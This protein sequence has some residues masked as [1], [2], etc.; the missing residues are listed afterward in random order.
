M[1]QR[2]LE[3]FCLT[4]GLENFFFFNSCGCWEIK[5]T[6]AS[7]ETECTVSH[8]N[9]RPPPLSPPSTSRP[10]PCGGATARA[11]AA[12]ATPSSWTRSAARP[13]VCPRSC[14]GLRRER[15]NVVVKVSSGGCSEKEAERTVGE[16]RG[17]YCC[18]WTGWRSSSLF[19]GGL[20]Q[21]SD[22]GR[23]SEMTRWQFGR[24]PTTDPLRERELH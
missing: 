20:W 4:T 19:P 24:S 11:P 8:C 21:S 10:V 12:P 17:A 9:T 6:S 14:P 15:Q 7:S 3:V 23:T 1:K 5:Q 18:R 13:A 22:T 16:Q 2:V